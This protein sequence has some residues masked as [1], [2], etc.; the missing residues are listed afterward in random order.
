MGVYYLGASPQQVDFQIV[1]V[2]T[3]VFLN[4]QSGIAYS[5]TR[6]SGQFSSYY[7][8]ASNLTGTANLPSGVFGTLDVDSFIRNVST[9]YVDYTV[10]TADDV[11]ISSSS[12]PKT[13]SLI[14]ASGNAGRQ[15]VIKNKGAGTVTV[16]ASGVGQIDG[17]NT[18]SLPQYES[19][20]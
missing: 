4:A 1:D 3:G 11:V 19:A 9:K 8:D 18:Y 12:D 14:S 17:A 20:K 16:N 2:D 10:S 7:T 13:I 5:S 6:L 15:F